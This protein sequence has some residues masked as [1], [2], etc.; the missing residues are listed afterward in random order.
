M[1]RRSIDNS[2]ALRLCLVGLV[3]AISVLTLTLAGCQTGTPTATP[4]EGIVLMTPS[5]VPETVE[6]TPVP[7]TPQPSETPEGYP[8]PPSPPPPIPTPEA[9]PAS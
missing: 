7:P 4:T 5:G 1:R 3:L 9:Y 8:A 6:A 2:R